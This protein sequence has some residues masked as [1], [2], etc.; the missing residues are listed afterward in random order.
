LSLGQPGPDHK[1]RPIHGGLPETTG[2]YLAIQG[3]KP[4]FRNRRGIRP[5]DRMES[6]TLAPFWALFP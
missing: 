5:D 4:R 2:E 3:V 1:A 6:E